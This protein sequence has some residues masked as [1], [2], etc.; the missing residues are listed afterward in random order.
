[1]HIQDLQAQK[2][3]LLDA[4]PLPSIFNMEAVKLYLAKPRARLLI[5]ATTE[6]LNEHVA[7][8]DAEFVRYRGHLIRPQSS[9]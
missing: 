6:S 5:A 1:M 9:N 8:L 4:T 3:T 7:M 2:L